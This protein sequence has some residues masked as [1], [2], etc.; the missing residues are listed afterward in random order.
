[1]MFI[2]ILT[3]IHNIQMIANGTL[4][5]KSH[6]IKLNRFILVPCRQTY[7][8]PRQITLCHAMKPNGFE[9]I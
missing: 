3:L 7:I 8:V 1:M 9:V 2:K 6:K 4:I 5:P